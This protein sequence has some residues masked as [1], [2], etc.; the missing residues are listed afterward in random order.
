MRFLPISLKLQWEGILS[1]KWAE[2]ARHEWTQTKEAPDRVCL[3]WDPYTAPMCSVCGEI[4]AV[5]L[6][7]HLQ[8][9][10]PLQT[11]KKWREL[12]WISYSSLGHFH[13]ILQSLLFSKGYFLLPSWPC[14]Q[15][16]GCRRTNF[17]TETWTAGPLQFKLGRYS[18]SVK[19]SWS[20]SFAKNT[21]S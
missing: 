16:L 13:E 9:S 12:A 8:I 21:N 4:L 2:L 19:K 5:M 17:H 11:L 3:W 18:S 10:I 15:L 14:K 7:F 6:V 20:C 1:S